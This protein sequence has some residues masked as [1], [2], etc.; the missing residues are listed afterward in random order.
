MVTEHHWVFAD[1]DGV[2]FLH[3]SH[4]DVVRTLD[5]EIELTERLQSQRIADGT[6]LREQFDFTTFLNRRGTDPTCALA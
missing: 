6:T 3:A 2:V 5:L 1:D 4:T